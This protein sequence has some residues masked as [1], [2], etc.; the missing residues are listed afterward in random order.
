[1]FNRTEFTSALRHKLWLLSIISDNAGQFHY[2]YISNV[3]YFNRLK[4]SAS[5]TVESIDLASKLV[6]KRS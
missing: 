3:Y 4:G 6:Y 5:R 1:M 2:S